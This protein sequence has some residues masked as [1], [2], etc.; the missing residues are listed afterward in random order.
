MV[1]ELR[2]LYGWPRGFD[3]LM[4]ALLT[5]PTMSQRRQSYPP[6]N[7]SEDEEAIYIQ[8][9]V[10]GVRMDDLDI[11]LT[12]STLT[13]QGEIKAGEGTYYRQERPFGAFQRV[14]RIHQDVD[15]DGIKATLKDGVLEVR[16]PKA[17]AL[18]PRKISIESA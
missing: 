8:C 14:V 6:L 9:E 13:I 10:P 7:L 15:R 4:D 1:T 3:R 12:E 2:S 5:S 17:E 16:L 18:K 11:T